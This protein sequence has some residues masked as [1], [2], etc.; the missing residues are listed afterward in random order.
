[1]TVSEVAQGIVGTSKILGVIPCGSGDGLAIHLGISRNP[2]KAVRQ[3]NSAEPSVMDYGEVDGRAFFCTTGVG[4]DAQVAWEFAREGKRGFWTYFAKTLSVWRR[5]VP[6]KYTLVI[7][8]AEQDVKAVFITVA[9]V[10][11]WGNNAIIA[12]GASVTDGLF[13]IVILHPFRVTDIPG[14]AFRLFSHSFSRNR[15][16]TVLRGRNVTIHRSSVDPAHLD[17]DSTEMGTDIRVEMHPSA[18]HVLVPVY[19][20][21]Q[22]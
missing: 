10:N 21:T 5:F 9:N 15:N 16:V 6:D 17:G 1:G 4:M 8:G 13:D 14:L 2:A 18:L 20:I 3:L 11:Q 22:I 7:D 19:H 12:P